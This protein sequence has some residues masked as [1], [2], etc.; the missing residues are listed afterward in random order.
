MIRKKGLG[1]EPKTFTFPLEASIPRCSH[2]TITGPTDA[3]PSGN[4]EIIF[5][6]LLP[7]TG[8]M[9]LLFTGVRKSVGGAG[10]DGRVTVVLQKLGLGSLLGIPAGL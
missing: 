1:F 10:L 7:P 4:K 6:P 8:R 3:G 2:L 5:Y 9:E